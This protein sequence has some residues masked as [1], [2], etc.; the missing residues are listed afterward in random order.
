MITCEYATPAVITVEEW[1]GCVWEGGEKMKI[2]KNNLELTEPLKKVVE[3]VVFDVDDESLKALKEVLAELEQTVD[4]IAEKVSR[5]KD[6]L[7]E[8]VQTADEG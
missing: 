8:V 2:V 7:A 5:L 3:V 6:T 4:R 1:K